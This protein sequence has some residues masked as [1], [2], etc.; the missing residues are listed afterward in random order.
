ME[1]IVMGFLVYSASLDQTFKVWRVKVMPEE[2]ICFDFADRN[3]SK[4]KTMEYE[5]SPV[6]SPNWVER[7]L[8]GNHFQ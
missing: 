8:Q 1:K 7:K 3:D 2:K 6:L 5:M 4:T